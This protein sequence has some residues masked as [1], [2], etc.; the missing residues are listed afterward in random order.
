MNMK[1]SFIVSI[2][3]L[4]ATIYVTGC[5]NKESKAQALL[6]EAISYS[7]GTPPEVGQ[8]KALKLAETKGF[9]PGVDG[10]GLT[11]REVVMVGSRLL[12]DQ[13]L[14]QYPSSQAA[15]KAA[16]MRIQIN[17]RLQAIA[18]DRAHSLFNDN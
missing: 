17:Q 16:E 2:L 13:I 8:Q 10:S 4:V 11:V 15:I 14:T 9:K 6:I 7:E 18:N 3:T 1:T 12:V 5:N